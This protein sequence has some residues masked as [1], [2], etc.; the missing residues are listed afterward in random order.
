[1]QKDE[2]L[3][4]LNK[5]NGKNCPFRRMDEIEI[6]SK[7]EFPLIIPNSDIDDFSSEKNINERSKYLKNQYSIYDQTIKS[8]YLKD[9]VFNKK[10]EIF[11]KSVIQKY[12]SSGAH[13]KVLLY[14]DKKSKLPFVS[15]KYNIYNEEK[16][17][18][19]QEMEDNR[20]DTEEYIQK[21][22]EYNNK[23]LA[24]KEIKRQKENYNLVKESVLG[25][26]LLNKCRYFLPNYPYNYGLGFCNIG[27][28]GTCKKISGTENM[29]DPILFQEYIENSVPL[30]EFVVD[31]KF[32]DYI[33]NIFLQIF[34][35]LNILQMMN[36]LFAHN[37]LHTNNI[38]IRK[39]KNK[40]LLP[41]YI[42]DNN[43]LQ[44]VKYIETDYIVYII[45]FGLSVYLSYEALAKKYQ[46]NSPKYAGLSKSEVKQYFILGNSLKRYL[47]ESESNEYDIMCVIKNITEIYLK[48]IKLGDRDNKIISFLNIMFGHIYNI[49]NQLQTENTKRKISQNQKFTDYNK[50]VTFLTNNSFENSNFK[51]YTKGK[52]L[53]DKFLSQLEI[54]NCLNIE[55]KNG[56]NFTKRNFNKSLVNTKLVRNFFTNRNNTINTML[57]YLSNNYTDKQKIAIKKINKILSYIRKYRNNDQILNLVAK[58]YGVLFP[59]KLIPGITKYLYLYKIISGYYNIFNRKNAS[60]DG[61][62]IYLTQDEIRKLFGIKLNYSYNLN[63]YHDIVK[64]II[65]KNEDILDKFYICTIIGN[66]DKSFDDILNDLD[67]IANFSNITSKSFFKN[68][69]LNDH[70]DINQIISVQLRNELDY[71]GEELSY[72]YLNYILKISIKSNNLYYI[73]YY[74]DINN[75]Y[76]NPT[77]DIT[78]IIRPETLESYAK[79]FYFDQDIFDFLVSKYGDKMKNLVPV[80]V[81]E[82]NSFEKKYVQLD[83]ITKKGYLRKYEALIGLVKP[84]GIE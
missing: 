5:F 59:E 19:E 50:V 8:C 10:P 64:M 4:L 21:E 73:K 13:G 11:E 74:S 44:E 22:I 67:D 53:S 83:D 77:E 39:L 62:V 14:S 41:I 84:L 12:I 80:L 46:E 43:L 20:E 7:D 27:E 37:D 49:K 40:I 79:N 23:K 6:K 57:T 9:S 31:P 81:K 45:D 17:Y 32:S 75:F 25:L 52:I 61:D 2:V 36:G 1:M 35:A 69:I 54:T 51:S 29:S 56:L 82:Y 3:E 72:N 55:C 34:N 68:A 78:D 66:D 18:S 30:S 60:K 26:E 15:G 28:N 24:K 16:T 63:K 70:R 47:K 42:F 48:K 38:L 58:L 76:Y 33:E 71:F 65:D